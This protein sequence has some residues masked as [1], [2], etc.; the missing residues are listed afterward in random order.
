[1]ESVSYRALFW[2][3]FERRV[4]RRPK[5]R[6]LP[7]FPG[8]DDFV[9]DADAGEGVPIVPNAVARSLERQLNSLTPRHVRVTLRVGARGTALRIR[10][11][12]YMQWKASMLGGVGRGEDE[13]ETQLLNILLSVQWFICNCTRRAWPSEAPLPSYPAEASRDAFE[14]HSSQLDALVPQPEVSLD[15]QVVRLWWEHQGRVTLA[16]EPISIAP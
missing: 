8:W 11:W 6:L 15:D 1:M 10:S 4:L 14:R 3:W 5:A 16:L 12:R 9:R 7:R 13:L 2:K